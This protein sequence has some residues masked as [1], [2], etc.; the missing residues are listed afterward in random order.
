[1]SWLQ[2][3]RGIYRPYQVRRF[4]TQQKGVAERETEILDE[5]FKI[6]IKTV[7]YLVRFKLQS[8]TFPVLSIPLVYNS[9]RG[10]FEI[11]ETAQVVE[12]RSKHYY[13]GAALPT[14][15]APDFYAP[16]LDRKAR[17]LVSLFGR[18]VEPSWV[19]G[20]EITAPAA[21]TAL[22]SRTV[23]AEK[24]AYIYG[25]F[26]STTEPNDFRI[27][28]TSGATSY[29]VRIPIGGKGAVHYVDFVALNEGLPANAG[30]SIT[31]TN[32]NAG[33]STSVY[34][35]RLLYAEV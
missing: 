20:S 26:I 3:L 9:Y 8:T 32:V 16:A 15:S 24:S 10:V 25:F 13:Y 6:D 28:W 2:M 11:A 14:L 7:E 22:V 5:R 1:M 23:S 12:A 18:D 31:I 34:Q 27:N 19:H 17:Q 29:S 33:G 30:S 4:N 35:A 21:D